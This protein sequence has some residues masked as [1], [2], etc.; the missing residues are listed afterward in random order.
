MILMDILVLI[1]TEVHILNLYLF[2]TGMLIFMYFC[3]VYYC[4]QP[5]NG[6]NGAKQIKSAFPPAL[7]V[8]RRRQRYI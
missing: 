4:S 2:Y 3:C 1:G 5:P 8:V 6:V 7:R